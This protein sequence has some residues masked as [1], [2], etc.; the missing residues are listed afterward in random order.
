MENEEQ[1]QGAENLDDTQDDGQ[2]VV[3]GA[4]VQPNAEAAKWRAIAERKTKQL[5]KVQA[6]L[7]EEKPEEKPTVP[8]TTEKLEERLFKVEHPELK[9]NLDLI[10]TLAKGKGISLDEAAKDEAIIRLVNSQ[11]EDAGVSVINSNRKVA[12]SSSDQAKKFERFQKEGGVDAL[13]ELLQVEE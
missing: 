4:D 11:K 10:K 2:A 8:S 9:D 7:K 1:P 6:S 3:E 5:E 13:A 12:P